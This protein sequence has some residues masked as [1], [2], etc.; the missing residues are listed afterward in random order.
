MIY[1]PGDMHVDERAEVASQAAPPDH[2]WVRVEAYIFPRKKAVLYGVGVGIAIGIGN[3]F[4]PL[5]FTWRLELFATLAAAI[6]IVLLLHEGLHG[7]VGALLGHRPIFGVE[8]PLVYTTFKK[9]IPRNHLIAIALAPLIILDI[10]SIAL[11]TSGRLALFAD[12]CFAVNTMGAVGDI[13][14]ALKIVRHDRAVFIQ[15]TKSGVEVWRLKS[16]SE[17]AS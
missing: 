4:L 9:K 1:Q 11:Y 14:I 7:G 12:L 15:D 16:G 3:A 10:A 6:L 8:P 13:W 17:G 5:D 2:G